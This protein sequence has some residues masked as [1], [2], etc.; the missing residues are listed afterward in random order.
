MQQAIGIGLSDTGRTL[1]KGG[2]RVTWFGMDTWLVSGTRVDADLQGLA[3]VSD[4]SDGWVAVTI[5]GTHA[6]E[7]LARVTP[8]DLRAQAFPQGSAARTEVQHMSVGLVRIAE[9]RFL[10]LGFRSMA[11]T[12]WHDLATAVQGVAARRGG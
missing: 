11:R 10:I 2:A 5:D 12:L 7:V 4:Q 9:T 3:A 6:A 8:L 1:S